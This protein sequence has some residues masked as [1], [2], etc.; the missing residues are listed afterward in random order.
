MEKLEQEEAGP[1]QGEI[2]ETLLWSDL[3]QQD[4]A[5]PTPTQAEP[6]ASVKPEKSEPVER[7][8]VTLKLDSIQLP[9]FDGDLTTWEAFR[10]MFEY[11]VD[12]STKLSDTVKFHQLRSHLKGVAYDTIR[13]YQLSGIN[14]RIAWNDVKKR[15][16]REEEIIDEYMRKFLEVPPI[17]HKA[18]Y[19]NLSNIVDTT[20]QMLRA[21]PHMGVEVSTWAPF[22]NL[23]IESKLDD[24]T[25]QDWKQHKGPDAKPNMKVLLDW[26][27]LR[28]IELQPSTSDRMSKRYQGNPRRP[29]QPKMFQQYN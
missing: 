24:D 6:E 3:C 12:Q 2:P 4:E 21:L 11:L 18:T 9:Y 22:V 13:G 16:D 15:F 10:D 14:Y 29:H 20:N 1:S 19:A 26:L 23:I 5:E 8:V 25:R 17:S 28:A 7:S 27:E